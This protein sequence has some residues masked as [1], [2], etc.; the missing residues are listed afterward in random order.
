LVVDRAEAVRLELARDLL[1]GLAGGLHLE[2]RLH[3]VEPRGGTH[4]AVLG[5]RGFAVVGHALSVPPAVPAMRNSSPAGLK[6]IPLVWRAHLRDSATRCS[7]AAAAPPP[8]SWP[9][10]SARTTAWS[11]FSTVR[12]P[13]PRQA[14][15][16]PRSVRPRE[17]SLQTVS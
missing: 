13:L 16:R 10:G 15:L 6:P 17:L 1:G 2:E 11:R 4:P 7:A 5:G 12:I 8:L 14:P 9:A 3:G